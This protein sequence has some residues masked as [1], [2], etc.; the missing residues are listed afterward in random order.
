MNYSKY[1]VSFETVFEN[2]GLAPWVNRSPHLLSP[3]GAAHPQSKCP[4]TR[5]VSAAPKGAHSSFGP[6]V[7]RVSFRALPSFHP[8]LCWS[9][10][11]AG[12]IYVFTTNQ[13][14]C[15][16]D[17]LALP[18]GGLLLAVLPYNGVIQTATTN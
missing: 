18:L 16:F 2:P 5:A 11:L 7:P 10:A 1:A 15:C 14:L 9:V 17:A 6:C 8:G 13:L 3:V 4:N 12:L